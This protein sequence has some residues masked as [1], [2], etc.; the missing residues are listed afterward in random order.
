MRSWLLPLRRDVVVLL[1]L[2][3]AMHLLVLANPGYYNHDELQR[4]DEIRAVGFWRYLQDHLTFHA[5]PHFGHPFRPA[6]F[7]QQGLG[8]LAMSASPM[9]AHALDLVLHSIVVLVLWGMLRS[10]GT[11]RR[12]AFLAAAIFAVSPLGT[13]ST[14]WVGASF[15]RLY[16]LFALLCAWGA[17]RAAL[18]GITL[19]RAL[20]IVTGASLALLSKE[21]AIMLPAALGLGGVA[22][23]WHRGRLNPAGCAAAWLL[24]SFVV[25]AYLALRWP[26]IV[27]SLAGAGGSYAPSADRVLDG[28]VLYFVQP[29]LLQ[30]VDLNS[31]R[32]LPAWQWALAI[33]AH[34][35]LL[36]L[37][38]R[39]CGV[40]RAVLYVLG[41]FVFLLP[42]L[43]IPLRGAH[44]LY[45]SNVA[46]ALAFAAILAPWSN[47]VAA[48]AQV[49]LARGVAVA[50]LGLLLMRSLTIQAAV[51]GQG[52]CQAQLERDLGQRFAQDLANGA[53]QIRIR[54]VDPDLE[55]IARKTLHAR[56]AY[57]VAG[58]NR[59]VVG[60]DGTP[61]ANELTLMLDSRCRLSAPR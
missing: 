59:V 2:C 32:L 20:V 56:S 21:T 43:P 18:A 55:P 51:F 30:A 52:R 58:S 60:Q 16:V 34:L 11:S 54:G 28:V 4:L 57:F 9:L 45:G 27:A 36:L 6:G 37:L 17:G 40:R 10:F 53:E 24:A 33:A 29:F 7:L 38:V 61:V 23:R 48:T 5:G 41:Y 8:A 1:A 3:L 31:A 39:Q 22:L 13:L 14:A 15:D 47:A 44:Y 25:I 35:A 46:F 49:R 50:L 19:S 42:V 12:T 26:A